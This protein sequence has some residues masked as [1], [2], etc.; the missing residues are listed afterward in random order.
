MKVHRTHCRILIKDM[1]IQECEK[2]YI[3]NEKQPLT[4]VD[5]FNVQLV[6]NESNSGKK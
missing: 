2:W 5:V 4:L 6:P 1:T 3:L